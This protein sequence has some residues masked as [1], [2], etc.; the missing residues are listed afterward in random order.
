MC[1]GCRPQPFGQGLA[2]YVVITDGQASSN[3]DV[4]HNLSAGADLVLLPTTPQARSV[5]LTIELS[6]TLRDVDIAHFARKTLKGV[7]VSDAADRVLHGGA[8]DQCM[9]GSCTAGPPQRLSSPQN[10]WD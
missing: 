4:L 5:E 7:C 9:S 10:N 2:A 3:D 8:A 1:G 6:A